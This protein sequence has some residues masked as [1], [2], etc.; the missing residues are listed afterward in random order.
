MISLSGL[1]LEM[2][3]TASIEDGWFLGPGFL[4]DVAVLFI[5]QLKWRRIKLGF[6]DA[7]SAGYS[8]IKET[9]VTVPVPKV[10]YYLPGEMKNISCL[11]SKAVVVYRIIYSRLIRGQLRQEAIHWPKQPSLPNLDGNLSCRRLLVKQCFSW[12]LR[13]LVLV[14]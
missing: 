3:F 5:W 1:Q 8:R 10:F 7:K 6:E 2:I 4:L 9:I 12:L 14:A 11:H 13:F